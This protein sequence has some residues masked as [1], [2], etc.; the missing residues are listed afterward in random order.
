[1]S[2]PVATIWRKE[3]SDRQTTGVIRVN[4]GP[5]LVFTSFTLELPWRNNE[6]GRSCVPAGFTY[7]AHLLWSNAWKRDL[8]ELIDVPG[9]SEVKIHPVNYVDG[10]RGCIALGKTLEDI[11]G[12]GHVDSTR[13]GIA[14]RDFHKALE[15][16][17]MIDV[18]VV[19]GNAGID[20]LRAGMNG[21]QP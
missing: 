13:S 16:H 10:L 2:I 14:V 17:Q 8:Y 21:Y 3:Y 11:N 9:R 4:I 7:R 12:D 20:H 18:V 19:S 5:L 15:G 1:M 6:N